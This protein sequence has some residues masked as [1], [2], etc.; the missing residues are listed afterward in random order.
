[1]KMSGT[2]SASHP[3]G[4]QEFVAKRQKNSL[5]IESGYHSDSQSLKA[6]LLAFHCW[7]IKANRVIY[8]S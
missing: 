2:A 5:K 7:T 8:R 6:A 3:I 1:M 4:L